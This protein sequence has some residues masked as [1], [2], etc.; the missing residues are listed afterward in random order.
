MPREDIR[1]KAASAVAVLGGAILWSPSAQ[2][3][4]AACAPLCLINEEY[5]FTND[6]VAAFGTEFLGADKTAMP[7]SSSQVLPESNP[8]QVLTTLGSFN[9]FAGG[10]QRVV[11]FNAGLDIFGITHMSWGLLSPLVIKA[12]DMFGAG[13]TIGSGFV[14]PVGQEV[15]VNP[16]IIS[17]GPALTG[18]PPPDGIRI[19]SKPVLNL[20]A[21]TISDATVQFLITVV[22]VT[23]MCEENISN[24]TREYFEFPIS[25]SGAELA[26]DNPTGQS[27]TLSDVGFFLSSKEVPLNQLNSLSLPPDDSRFRPV[28]GI[29]NGTVLG[30]GGSVTFSAAPKKHK[31]GESRRSSGEQ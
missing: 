17:F 26:F 1:I 5:V 31:N 8:P 21:N 22:A 19:L 11:T 30:A 15:R 27:E 18:A 6:D 28:S 3:V 29:P 2:A 13:F 10:M 23:T 4:T 9:F 24:T 14:L 16:G 7:R 25:A 20:S 12:G